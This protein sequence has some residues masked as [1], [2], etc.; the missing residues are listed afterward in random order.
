MSILLGLLAGMVVGGGIVYLVLNNAMKKRSVGILKEA[1]LEAE[2][3]KKEKIVQAKEKF[4]QLKEDHE[5]DQCRTSFLVLT[6]GVI[7]CLNPL[8]NN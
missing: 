1:E 4:L 5:K 7:E 6:S 2:A 8:P 3:L